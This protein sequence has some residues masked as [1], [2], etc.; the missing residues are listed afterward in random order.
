M[1]IRLAILLPA[2]AAFAAGRPAPAA[3]SGAWKTFIRPLTYYDLLA[4]GD[5]ILCATGEAGLLRY[6]RRDRSFVAIN[7]EP[8]GLASNHL[9]TLLRDRSGRLWVGTLG[10]GASRLSADGKKWDLVNRFDGLPS[11]SVTAF[12]AR[13]DTLLIGT[14]R[15]IALWNGVEIA[16]ALPDGFNPS[17]FTN[18]SDWITGIVIHGDSAW[19]STQAGVYRSR[20]SQGLTTWTLENQGI[21]VTAIEGIVADDTTLIALQNNTPFKHAFDTPGPWAFAKTLAGGTCIGS[22]PGCIPPAVRIYED[23]GKILLTTDAGFFVWD[24]RNGWLQLTQQFGSDRGNDELSFA[25]TVAPDG[26]YF[27][28]DRDGLR[29]RVGDPDL[30]ANHVL[31]APPGNDIRNVATQGQRVYVNTRGEGIGRFDG[32]EWY[33]WQPVRCTVNC[34][35][36]LLVPIEAFALLVDRQGMKWFG[37][38][39]L[40]LDMLDDSRSPPA[41][42]HH[43]YPP[44]PANNFLHTEAWAAAAD[45]QGGRWFGMDTHDF[46]NPQ[47]EALGLEYY[48]ATGVYSANYLSGRIHGLT[49]DRAGRIW[50]GRL[51]GGIDYFDWPPPGGGLTPTFIRVSG[52]DRS[53]VQ[54]LVA[55]GDTVWALTNSELVAYKR[56]NGTRIVSYAVPAGPGTLPVNPLAVERDGTVWAGTANGIRVIRPNGNTEDINVTNSPLPVDDVT[57]IRAD[58]Q[59]GLV[60]IGTTGGLIRYDPGYRPPLPPPVPELKITIYPNPAWLS[61][62][63]I[64]V[65]LDGNA[66]GYSGAVYDLNG[67]RVNRFAGVGNQ[68]I[69]WDGHTEQGDLARPGIYFIRV[70]SS[71]KVATS[72]VI[73]LR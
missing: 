55:H 19:V 47:A 33:E 23:R 2:L 11:D 46:G 45:S 24:P 4:E 38:W 22:G 60:W 53:F 26:R 25:L 49:V 39:A 43:L 66:T 54:G 48:D 72:R 56:V 18:G 8:N 35:T 67:R 59:T 6:E 42:V 28:A 27:A 65:K 17:P 3:A 44:P 15:G 7:R 73:L 68:G 64:A 29:E 69:V 50:V 57:S 36:T 51:D 58:W 14:T 31:A 13:G 61:S 21:P 62:V 1:R 10:A 16:G 71:G 37:C 40:V 52:T 30:W 32:R 5:T 41:V 34:D 63:G 70:R 20:F 9:S 12:A